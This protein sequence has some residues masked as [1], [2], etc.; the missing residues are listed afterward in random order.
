MKEKVE[1]VEITPAMA[2]EMLAMNTN[3]RKM[4]PAVV[5]KY[6]KD[7][8]NDKWVFGTCQIC[9][10]EDGT[11]LDGQ[12]RLKAII[13]ANKAVPMIVI[14]NMCRDAIRVIDSGNPRNVG[15][16]FRIEGVNYSSY[17]GGIAIRFQGMNNQIYSPRARSYTHQE[18]WD[19]YQEHADWYDEVAP[20]AVAWGNQSKL[21]PACFL[22]ALYLH[23][24]K[25]KHHPEETVDKFIDQICDVVPTENET[26]CN[27]RRVLTNFRLVGQKPT[28]AQ[29]TVYVI[30]T[31]NAYLKNRNLKVFK[32]MDPNDTDIWFI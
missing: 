13:E 11:L 30:K 15:D 22:G 20:K 28:E 16:M 25:T 21:F 4:K 18:Y 8:L 19:L 3:N 31:W 12:H 10:A 17:I 23:L 29:I 24:T 6:K 7:L 27:L 1:V 14:R 9:F 2:A 5:E 26:I 32:N